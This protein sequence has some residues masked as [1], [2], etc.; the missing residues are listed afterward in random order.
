MRRNAFTLIELLVV[1]AIIALLIAIL[2][3]SLQE[4][5]KVSVRVACLSN[6]RQV[7]AAINMYVIDNKGYLPGP[8]SFGQFP[9]YTTGRYAISRYTAIYLGHPG[10]TNKMQINES[11]VCP[12][13]ARVAPQGIARESWIIFGADSVDKQHKRHLGTPWSPSYGPTKIVAIQH[14]AQTNLMREID[15]LTNPGGW[16]GSVGLEPSHGFNGDWPVRNYLYFDG[17]A[18]SVVVD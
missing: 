9:G 2:M 4:A 18:E 10:P 17:H 6:M 15:E 13:F 7:S 5:R 11:F 12:G 8:C 16:G 1:V 3:P 14:A